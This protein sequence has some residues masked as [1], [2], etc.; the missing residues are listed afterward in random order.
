MARRA[1]LVVV[2]VAGCAALTASAGHSL[3]PTTGI[4]APAPFTLRE[5]NADTDNLVAA[6][7]TV[8]ANGSPVSGVRVR[9]DN[10]TVPT[11][12]DKAGHFVYLA[13]GTLLERHVVTITDASKAKING[14]PISSAQR[15]ALMASVGSI[16]VSYAVRDLTVSKNGA[17]DPVISGRLEKTDTTGPPAVGLLTYQLT[18]TITDSNGK[19][20]E[21]AQV[22]TRTLD[23]DYW[24]VSTVSDA[25]GHYDSLFTASAEVSGNPVPFTVRVSKGDAVYQFLQAEFVDFQRLKSARLDIRLPPS[26]YAFALPVPHSYPGALYTGTVVGVTSG[27]NVI[28]PVS[29]T[30]PTAPV[31]KRAGTGRFTITLPK[32]LAGKTVSIW[33]DTLNLFSVD[34]AKPGGPIDLQDW[35]TSLPSHAPRGLATVTLK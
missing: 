31:P 18:G 7:G 26:G 16:D 30:W 35:P 2:L 15:N 12:T 11:P 10:Y 33:E 1:L 14:Q 17:G 3:Q 32:R 13:D 19:P 6:Q 21:G 23:R 22:S 29:A 5:W 9:V 20:V 27:G 4:V 8:V 28:R 34:V 25:K 24:T